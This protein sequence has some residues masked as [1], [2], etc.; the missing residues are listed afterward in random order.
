[1]RKHRGEN[2]AFRGRAGDDVE[3][4]SIYDPPNASA[5]PLIKEIFERAEIPFL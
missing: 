5:N 2:W 3:R 1:M 4:T